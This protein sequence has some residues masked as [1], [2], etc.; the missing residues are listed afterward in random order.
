MERVLSVLRIVFFWPPFHFWKTS[1]NQCR[2]EVRGIRNQTG[3]ITDQKGGIWEHSPGIRDHKPWNRDQQCVFFLF[4]FG[5]GGG[6]GSDIR[7][8]HFC[9]I[10]DQN[11]SRF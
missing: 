2:N 5:G 9:V 8:Y 1:E 3:G 6:G 11:L 10:K 7:L 4:F